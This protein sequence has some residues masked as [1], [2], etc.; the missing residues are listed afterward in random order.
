MEVALLHPITSSP[1]LPLYYKLVLLLGL[2]L[3][4]ANVNSAN[5]Y[6]FGVNALDS[7]LSIYELLDQ[8]VVKHHS[9]YPTVQN[10]KAVAVRPNGK[11]VFVISKPLEGLPSATLPV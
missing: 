6:A 7:T 2:C 9:F 4:A 8:G 10:P 11:F 3:F 5:K 1:P